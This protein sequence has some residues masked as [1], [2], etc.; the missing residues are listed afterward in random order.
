MGDLSKE[1]VLA[2]GLSEL[3]GVLAQSL[4]GFR[5]LR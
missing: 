3:S 4:R 1:T 5:E 2:E